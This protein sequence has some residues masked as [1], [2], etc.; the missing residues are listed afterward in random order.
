MPT[1]E[2]LRIKELKKEIFFLEEKVSGLSKARSGLENE[3]VAAHKDYKVRLDKQNDEQKTKEKILEGSKNALTIEIET[4]A[5]Q[6]DLAIKEVEGKI[7]SVES[8]KVSLETASNG[9]KIQSMALA[10][11]RINLDT[12][13]LN[14]ETAQIN[15]SKAQ[16]E[17]NNLSAK[18]QDIL[19]EIEHEKDLTIEERNSIKELLEQIQKEKKSIVD[20]SAYKDD[21]AK[22]EAEKAKFEAKKKELV[23]ASTQQTKRENDILEREKATTEKEKYLEIKERDL[24]RDL[25]KKIEILNKLRQGVPVA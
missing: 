11:E 7:K 1:Q 2:E 24:K 4:F 9:L 22:L 16:E 5:R 3:V 8:D 12:K 18:N 6:K 13:A 15:I 21:L 14:V 20:L 23:K 17:L 19:D 25:D 10:N